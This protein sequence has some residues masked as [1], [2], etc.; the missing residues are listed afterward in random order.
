MHTEVRDEA[1]ARAEPVANEPSVPLL[2]RL[3]EWRIGELNVKRLIK[4]TV[5]QIGDNDIP[6]LAAEMAY[7][8]ALAFFPFLLF[9]AGL[10]AVMDQVFGVEDFTDRLVNQLG[11]V[12]SEDATNVSRS[13]I[14]DVRQSRGAGAAIFGL[15]GALWAGSAEIGSAMKGLNRIYDRKETRSMISRKLLA[16]SL[17][18]IFSLLLLAAVIVVGAG[19]VL[20]RTV[21]DEL[22][23]GDVAESILA[24]L[25]WPL[26][27]LL[28][29]IAVAIVYWLGPAGE[30][31]LRWVTPGAGIF[32]VG[33][34]LASAVFAVYISNF[35]TYNTA[36]GSLGAAIIL[37]VW[38][39]WS[40]LLLL[41][42]AQVNSLI[43]QVREGPDND[44]DPKPKTTQAQP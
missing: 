17:A 20:A 39:Y 8:S 18:I 26:S 28:V 43:E 21:A 9:L 2:D 30:S 14:D 19:E 6:G 32:A 31:K 13:V 7:H 1:G 22:N 25:A 38:L 23:A 11:E 29:V 24:V 36:Y 37:L 44:I 33:W 4:E 3:P 10:T 42:G 12:L 16:I 27:I 34:L 35:G 40:N 41:M 15:L 5:A